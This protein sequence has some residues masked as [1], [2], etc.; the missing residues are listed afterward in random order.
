[1]KSSLITLVV[2]GLL[3]VPASVPTAKTSLDSAEVQT[4][5]SGVEIADIYGQPSGNLS[6]ASYVSGVEAAD[7]FDQQQLD[8]PPLPV[9][10]SGVEAADQLCL[11]C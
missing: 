3:I 5:V 6:M 1:M 2:I 8:S 10:V 11:Y 9:Y 4:Y 7:I